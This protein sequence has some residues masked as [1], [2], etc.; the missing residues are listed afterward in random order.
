MDWII[1][2]AALVF[3]TLLAFVA[4]AYMSKRKTEQ[5]MDDESAT[6]STLAADKRS[7]GSPADV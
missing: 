4:F 5:R 1:L 2:T 3:T 6:K 7:D